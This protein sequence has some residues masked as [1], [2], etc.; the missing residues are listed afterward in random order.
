MIRPILEY[1]CIIYDNC[2]SGEA[3][4]LESVQLDAAH[5]CTGSLWKTSKYKLLE[6]LGWA[7][8]STRRKFFKLCT[9]FKMH[10]DLLPEYLSHGRLILAG[11]VSRY[12]LRNSKNWCVPFARTNKYKLSFYSSAISA[13]NDLSK[14]FSNIDYINS[15]KH[16]LPPYF[17]PVC[18]LIL[19]L[20]TNLLPYII[21]N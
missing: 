5:V 16:F 18:H 21:P 11:D 4:L 1:G 20:V 17:P 15:K 7:T 8:L 9:L 12:P 6:E 2:P 14:E 13:Y 19:T 3:E 10:H